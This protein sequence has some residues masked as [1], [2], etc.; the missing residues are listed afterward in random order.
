MG[1]S[2]EHCTNLRRRLIFGDLL[3]FEHQVQGNPNS[4]LNLVLEAPIAR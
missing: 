1:A 4:C 3:D 2:I